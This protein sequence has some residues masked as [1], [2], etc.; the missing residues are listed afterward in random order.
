M[1]GVIFHLKEDH[2]GI[3]FPHITLVARFHQFNQDFV[4]DYYQESLIN[5]GQR[6]SFYIFGCVKDHLNLHKTL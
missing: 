6:L 2:D 4:C 3:M 1:S 5:Q